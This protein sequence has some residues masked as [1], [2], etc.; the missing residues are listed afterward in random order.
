MQS[1]VPLC[2]LDG[3]AKTAKI[4]ISKKDPDKWNALADDL[5]LTA[6]QRE[7]HFE[8]GEYARLELE[9]DDQLRVIGGRI[10]PL[11]RRG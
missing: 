1:W 7:A 2:N 4:T 11:G 9:I 6:A 10:V 5:E 3:M 8:F